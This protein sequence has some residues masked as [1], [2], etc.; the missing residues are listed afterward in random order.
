[1]KAK[2]KSPFRKDLERLWGTVKDA[3][4]RAEG[5]AEREPQP[6]KP[7]EDT[8]VDAAAYGAAVTHV[9]NRPD[10]IRARAQV[11]ATISV[12]AAAALATIGGLAGVGERKWWLQVLVLV[13]VVLWLWSVR[14]YIQA[15]A[16]SEPRKGDTAQEQ[17]LEELVGNF[18]DYAASMRRAVR[19]GTASTQL[20]V[21]ATLFAALGLFIE[22]RLP[23]PDPKP[24][25]PKRMTVVLA[26][27]AVP[28]IAPLC[29]VEVDRRLEAKLRPEDLDLEVV[30]LR[31]VKPQCHQDK[32]VTVY[33]RRSWIRATRSR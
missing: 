33:I 19:R 27:S 13:A 21:V 18:L 28:A 12:A 3:F 15:I 1:V 30:P 32:A 16:Y 4:G 26:P 24:A 10:G 11:S 2:R 31:L 6:K 5:D 8:Q 23:D 29:G 20:A 9:I 25:N 7:G 22:S 17:P 14:R